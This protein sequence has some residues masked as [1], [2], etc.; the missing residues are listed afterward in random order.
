MPFQIGDMVEPRPEWLEDANRVPSGRVRAIARW[1][2]NGALYVGDDPRAFA[3][4][5]F[6]RADPD[7]QNF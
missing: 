6:Q 3:A 4:E 1:G 7:L 2:E 5:V